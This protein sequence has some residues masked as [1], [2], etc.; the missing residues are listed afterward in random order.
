MKKLILFSLMLLIGVA[1]TASA[2]TI[3]DDII[4]RIA[5]DDEAI[6][7][8]AFGVKPANGKAWLPGIMSRKKQII[9]DLE[10]AFA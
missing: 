3:G 8:K 10:K 5:S 9:P 6:V 1:G 4:N 7:E 2:V